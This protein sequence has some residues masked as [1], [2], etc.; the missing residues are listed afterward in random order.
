ME[1]QTLSD[2]EMQ[3]RES[4]QRFCCFVMEIAKTDDYGFSL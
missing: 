3:F 1:N 2:P 4:R